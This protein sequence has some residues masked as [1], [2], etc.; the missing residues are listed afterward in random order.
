MFIDCTFQDFGLYFFEKYCL[1]ISVHGSKETVLSCSSTSGLDS[2]PEGSLL[3]VDGLSALWKVRIPY[4]R[5]HVWWFFLTSYML[6]DLAW[7]MNSWI[8]RV[9]KAWQADC[10][11]WL[12]AACQSRLYRTKTE[13]YKNLQ[14]REKDLV[15]LEFCRAQIFLNLKKAAFYSQ[16]S[17]LLTE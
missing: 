6:R 4:W 17:V 16:Q 2:F 5:G 10:R 8:H 15:S 14:C 9:N 1:N 12:W 13:K 11:P 7:P 3:D